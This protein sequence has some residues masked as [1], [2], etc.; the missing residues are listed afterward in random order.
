MPTEKGVQLHHRA[1]HKRCFSLSVPEDS[2]KKLSNCLQFL[3]IDFNIVLLA[4]TSQ[5]KSPEQ[6]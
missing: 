6:Y 4:A 2:Q 5:E 3:V 1:L